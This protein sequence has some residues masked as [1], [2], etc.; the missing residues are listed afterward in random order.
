MKKLLIIGS[1]QSSREAIAYLSRKPKRDFDVMAINGASEYVN[2]D[3]F[4]TLDPSDVNLSY[5]ISGNDSKKHYMATDPSYVVPKE[6]EDL[7]TILYRKEERQAEPK[8]KNSPEWW[9]W[10]WRC[11]GGLSIDKKIINSG[12]SAFGGLG[13]AYHLGYTNVA[14]IGVDA[15]DNDRVCGGKTNNLS[16][17]PL[18]FDSALPFINVVNCG[19]MNSKLPKVSFLEWVHNG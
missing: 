10:R 15:D 9:F 11:V 5:I 3:L 17:L 18:L 8:D 16:H 1:G 13:L 7:C 4:F 14:L 19:Y 12:N 6:I 2:Y